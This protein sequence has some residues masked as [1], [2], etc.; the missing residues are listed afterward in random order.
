[1]VKYLF[2]AIIIISIGFLYSGCEEVESDLPVTYSANLNP[3]NNSGVNGSATL[4]LEGNT[5]QV[6]IQANGLEPL[7]DHPQ[8]IRGFP[9]S[10][11]NSTCPPPGADTDGNGIVGIEEGKLFYGGIKLPLDTTTASS[12][13]SLRY[14]DTFTLGEG[15]N[16]ELEDLESLTSRAIVLHGMT[17]NGNYEPA[18]PV[19]CGQLVLSK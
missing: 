18:L 15:N 5:L 19:A 8:Y 2:S 13:G 4:I 11:E 6:T 16:P 7:K 3:I 1:M 9:S 17:I 12:N 10:A 14:E